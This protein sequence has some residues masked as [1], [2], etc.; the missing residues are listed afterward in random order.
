MEEKNELNKPVQALHFDATVEE[1]EAKQAPATLN[2][3]ETMLQDDVEA[4]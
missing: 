3:N 1:L 2:H 4:D